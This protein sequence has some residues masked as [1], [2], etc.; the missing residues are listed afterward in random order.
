[1]NNKE[2]NCFIIGKM[3]IKDTT[4]MIRQ[5]KEVFIEASSLSA[6]NTNADMEMLEKI[7]ESRLEFVSYSDIHEFCT[8]FLLAE[9]QG[10]MNEKI[11]KRIQG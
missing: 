9:A 5:G 3:D 6:M 8:E 1:M 4:N 7:I 2:L 11:F 10:L